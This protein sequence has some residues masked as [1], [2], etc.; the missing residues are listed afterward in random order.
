MK[1]FSQRRSLLEAAKKMS[2]AGFSHGTSGN[3]S[4][5]VE[6]GIL[7]TPTG[8][9]YDETSPEDLV[10][11]RWDGSV[12]TGQRV[13]SS[14][15]RIHRDLYQAR[16]DAAAIFHAH[17]MYC[18]TLSCHLD[19]LAQVSKIGASGHDPLGAQR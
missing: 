10:E 17:P 1:Y 5:R 14:E 13:P 3:V 16:D 18:T 2:A 4:V 9:T 7:V 8:M 15:W 11:V 19:H 6:D 12:P